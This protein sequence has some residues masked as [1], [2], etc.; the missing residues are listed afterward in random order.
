VAAGTDNGKII[1][2]D[3]DVIIYGNRIFGGTQGDG[4]V[5]NEDTDGVIEFNTIEA[6]PGRGIFI[7]RS[8]STTGVDPEVRRNV[9]RNNGGHGVE[10]SATTNQTA[11][12]GPAVFL[13][14]I[15]SNAGD[16]VHIGPGVIDGDVAHNTFYGNTGSGVELA[17]CGFG[18]CNQQELEVSN[19]LFIANGDCGVRNALGA[20]EWNTDGPSLLFGNTGGDYC[21]SITPDPGDIFTLDPL[22]TDAMMGDFRLRPLSPARNTG[23]IGSFTLDM[24]HLGSGTFNGSA[25]EIGALETPP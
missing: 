13:N 17:D 7:F 1:V 24:N 16:G 8:S 21:G 23:T 22:F 2:G 9:I 12:Q 4:I 15:A 3:Q 25:A 5:V 10:I 19:N 6:N 14:V 20:G 18:S 11:E